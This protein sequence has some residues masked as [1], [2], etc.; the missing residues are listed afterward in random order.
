MIG[1]GDHHGV[2]IGLS[3]QFA[4]ILKHPAA[5]ERILVRLL[6]VIA[7]D[8]LAAILTPVSIHVAHG[9]HLSAFAAEKAAQQPS[10]L[11]PQANEA[12]G[13]AL[14]GRLFRRPGREQE[15]GRPGQSS[16]AQE[17]TP[18]DPTHGSSPRGGPGDNGEGVLR[19]QRARL[20]WVARFHRVRLLILAELF[21]WSQ[22]ISTLFGELQP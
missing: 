2:N 13:D 17:S 21:D 3:H 10:P 15:R 12:Q 16:L 5:L 8:P 20:V 18:R 7:F 14:R 6:P 22:S 11:H 1:G 19:E 9:D 4:K